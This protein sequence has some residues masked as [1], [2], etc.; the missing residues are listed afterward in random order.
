[1]KALLMKTAYIVY[2][3]CPVW[4]QNLAIS[5]YG[6]IIYL[7]RYGRTYRK[8]L[9]VYRRRDY[10]SDKRNR[11]IQ[12]REFMK[13]LNYAANHSDFYKELY[14]DIDLSTIKSVE[15]IGRLPIVS[16]EAFKENINR[17][18][19]IPSFKGIKLYTGGTTG[20]PMRIL[21]RR[22]DLQKRLAYLD[23]YKLKYGF[24]ANKMRCARFIGKNIILSTPHNH[25]YWRENYISQQRYYSTYHLTENNMMYYVDSL[26]T[27]HPEAID[28]FVSA[29]YILAKY[30]KD[31]HLTLSFIPKVIFTTSETVLPIHR[32]M[33]E[34]VFRCPLSDQ[35]ASNDGAPFIT[36]CSYG[37]YHE[38]IDTGVFEHIKTSLGVK[39]IV[40]GF[41]SYGT[42]LIRYD[43]GDYILET[44]RKT[45]PCGSCHPIIAAIDGRTTDYLR[46]RSRGNISQAALSMLI[47]EL[48]DCFTQ[49]QLLQENS[50]VI[51]VKAVLKKTVFQ[52]E[53]LSLLKDKLTR[54]LGND[55]EFTIEEVDY[56]EREKSGKFRM[57]INRMEDLSL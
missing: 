42:P 18:Y 14:Q 20:I 26:N 57:I 30:I 6:L 25:V 37:T 32:E 23:A 28:G 47:S 55:M 19:T 56:I 46:T 7:Q 16:K 12:N 44:E 53:K 39:L 54:Y 21:I 43:I 1:M 52:E 34:R 22:R 17:L 9:K 2:K 36:Q 33:I 38:N 5:F 45:C 3:H 31:H 15:D 50:Q 8:Y 41:H 51:H 29:I 35:Y 13:L 24:Q 10:S 4:T 49:L 40:T 27:Y 48:P 11:R